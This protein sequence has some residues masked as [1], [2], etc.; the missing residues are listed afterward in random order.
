[1]EENKNEPPVQ[2]ERSM[3]DKVAD[4]AWQA[5]Y[6]QLEKNV[7]KSLLALFE[8][9][10]PGHAVSSVW[11]FGSRRMT[12]VA[13]DPYVVTVALD[14]EGPQLFGRRTVIID[15]RPSEDQLGVLVAADPE[16]GPRVQDGPPSLGKLL[17][18]LASAR[19]PDDGTP[20]DCPRCRA[21]RANR[22]H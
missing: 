5:E 7:H 19:G 9:V 22:G 17:A 3:Q 4:P 18:A 8:F 11:R 2:G 21:E 15:D 16:S 6:L 20:C 10:G 13:G 12:L 1:M 14:K